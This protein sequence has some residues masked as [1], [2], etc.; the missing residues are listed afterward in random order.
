MET[1]MKTIL[2]ASL[3]V[4]ASASVHATDN[5]ASFNAA[6]QDAEAV[7]LHAAEVKHEWRDTEKMLKN[8]KALAA[9]G[10]YE[11][12]MA[13]VEHAKMESERAVEQAEQQ[14]RVWQDAVPK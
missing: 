3:L 10:Q 9:E 5:E 11:Q 14:A 1:S 6:W 12:A 8:A 13:L 4:I 2:A 7:R